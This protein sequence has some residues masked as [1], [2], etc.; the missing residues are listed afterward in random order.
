MEASEPK[1]VNP[2]DILYG[3]NSLRFGGLQ[4][5]DK[6]QHKYSCIYNLKKNSCYHIVKRFWEFINIFIE[7]SQWTMTS[8]IPFVDFQWIFLYWS[9]RSIIDNNKHS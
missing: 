7:I 3:V 9:M 4:I 2:D 1:W 6:K 5:L 8:L